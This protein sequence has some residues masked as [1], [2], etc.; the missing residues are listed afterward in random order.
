MDHLLSFGPVQAFRYQGFYIAVF[1]GLVHRLRLGWFETRDEA[2]EAI[3]AL[4]LMID[5]VCESEG[6]LETDICIDGACETWEDY[7]D[8]WIKAR[9]E[10]LAAIEE[11]RQGMKEALHGQGS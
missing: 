1:V 8:C 6:I 9:P 10:I 4:R 11:T 5:E 2:V 3:A 7:E